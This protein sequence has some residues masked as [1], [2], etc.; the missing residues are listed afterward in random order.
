LGSAAPLW[1]DGIGGESGKYFT[2]KEYFD[3][4]HYSNQQVEAYTDSDSA[5]YPLKPENYGPTDDGSLDWYLNNYLM[6]SATLTSDIDTSE[7]RTDPDFVGRVIPMYIAQCNPY[8]DWSADDRVDNRWFYWV[9]TRDPAI[10]KQD[11]DNTIR[12]TYNG[13]YRALRDGEWRQ[14]GNPGNPPSIWPDWPWPTTSQFLSL[15]DNLYGEGMDTV[16]WYSGQSSYGS[17]EGGSGQDVSPG[18]SATQLLPLVLLAAVSALV[19]IMYI[20]WR[21]SHGVGKKSF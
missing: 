21:R 13:V 16:R 1:S 10:A 20:R 3:A 17:A 8:D 2:D 11:A 4:T 5:W 7:Y 6:G 14:R 18:P 9:D 12:L 15:N 19:V